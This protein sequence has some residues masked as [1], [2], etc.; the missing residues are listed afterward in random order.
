MREG[1]EEEQ[2]GGMREWR[3]FRILRILSQQRAPECVC[4]FILVC[5]RKGGGE[6]MRERELPAVV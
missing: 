1:N 6:L 4:V 3:V 2:G 5:V